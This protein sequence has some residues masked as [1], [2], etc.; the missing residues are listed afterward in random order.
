M[1]TTSKNIQ[2]NTEL[3][4]L[5]PIKTGLAPKPEGLPTDLSFPSRL[6]KLLTTLFGDRKRELERDRI[7]EGL[8]EQ[9][10]VIHSVQWVIV[11]QLE[12]QLLLAVTFDGPW[13]PYIR[14]IVD[15]A[16]P[17]LDMIFSHCQGFE[18][19]TCQNGYQ[20]FVRW[21]RSRQVS[22]QFLFGAAPDLTTDD[23]RYL[24]Q[25]EE[26]FAKDPKRAE[27]SSEASQTVLA[28]V[29]R[30]LSPRWFEKVLGLLKLSLIFPDES[31]KFR[32]MAALILQPE[33]A[34]FDPASGVAHQ[35]FKALS[36]SPATAPAIGWFQ[37]LAGELALPPGSPDALVDDRTSVQGSILSPYTFADDKGATHGCF[38]L[39]RFRGQAAAARFLQLVAQ[40]LSTEPAVPN[41]PLAPGSIQ[42]NLGLTYT[43]LASLGLDEQLLERLPKEF[44]EGPEQRAG[45]LGDFGRNHPAHWQLPSANWPANAG[46]APAEERIRLS[47][48][49]AVLVLQTRDD[50]NDHTLLPALAKFLETF[51]EVADVLHVQPTRRFT[52][53]GHFNLEDG[54]SQPA[55][56]GD[57]TAAK[58]LLQDQV[59]L[60]E[61]LLGYP[62][63][64]HEV[65]DLTPPDLFKNSTFMALRKMSQDVEA[66]ESLALGGYDHE[67]ALGRRAQGE[68][69]EQESLPPGERHKNDFS[70][71]ASPNESRCPHFAHVRRANP[72]SEPKPP[73][74]LRRGMSYGPR[75]ADD[76]AAPRGLMFM[77]FAAS[78]AEQYEV[79]QRWVNAGNSTG[80]LSS[81]P[82][83]IAGPFPEGSERHLYYSNAMGQ[84]QI[85]L[86]NKQLSVL[87]WALY[88]FIPSKRAL[89][90]L[91]GVARDGHIEPA[92]AA[93][94]AP[95][96]PSDVGAPPNALVSPPTQAGAH[97]FDGNASAL[98]LKVFLEGGKSSPDGA[99]YW[100]GIQA[101]GG[102]RAT[103]FA[104]LLASQAAVQ[105]ALLD[106][107]KFSVRS[108]WHRMTHCSAQSYLG[109]DPRPV[110]LDDG[111]ELQVKAGDHERESRAANAFVHAMTREQAFAPALKAGRDWL[112]EQKPVLPGGPKLLSLFGYG[113]RII[114]DVATE[115]FGLPE[116]FLSDANNFSAP[117]PEQVRCPFDLT[118]AFLHVF[119]PRPS[120]S[121]SQQAV[122]AGTLV[123]QAA[124]EA[125]VSK[126]GKPSPLEQSRF[127]QALRNAS[128]KECA[129]ESAEARQ[130]RELRTLMG[131]L[132]GFAVP[133]N[134]HLVSVLAQLAGSEGL[135]RLQRELRSALAKLNL[136]A[137]DD[138]PKLSVKHVQ[139]LY[140]PLFACMI[141]GAVPE[142]LH[143]TA[144]VD[145]TLGGVDIKRGDLV[146]V[147]IAAAAE[148]CARKAEAAGDAE[149]DAWRLLFGDLPRDQAT[150]LAPRRPEHRCPAPDVAIGVLLGALVALLE[151]RNL[152]RTADDPFTLIG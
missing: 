15:R 146:A 124:R 31:Q 48:V 2:G 63:E 88:T 65:S 99:A 9:L 83:L 58:S 4:L 41:Q 82:D 8:L 89:E 134:G 1:L 44:Q 35:M 136:E 66:Y 51:A 52:T 53:A 120:A 64:R 106:S 20:G 113:A 148:E 93:V 108:Y 74:I 50:S 67:L 73:R 47:L 26:T 45:M 122:Q 11:G 121:V 17:L 25:F 27:L 49:D 101:E 70:Y 138:G 24:K 14:T 55:A 85:R 59:S 115:L 112:N 95:A 72:R 84:G 110:P 6:T 37:Q 21:V 109:M 119:P 111:Y 103:P 151:Y 127:I 39:V 43:G 38:A 13:E 140:G 116:G 69:L 3:T 22:T 91:V 29:R 135:W 114:R 131:V 33:F 107:D 16:G 145:T 86:P 61:L 132:S 40:S 30:K 97:S 23:V 102:V 7:V 142:R 28:P 94:V 98:Q 104:V 87:E 96:R 128:A 137:D 92:A 12:P 36:Q 19:N 71:P 57:Q 133:T 42:L 32:R 150:A 56:R 143:R 77:A 144:V 78:L 129:S 62:N 68:P 141:R 76:A 5:V 125:F 118:T 34:V 139:F 126:N 152:D 10:Q 80:V 100:R 79:V 147:S 46:G 117:V 123:A 81:H 54:L 18:P 60:G 130:E 90:W 149:H 75:Y 105:E